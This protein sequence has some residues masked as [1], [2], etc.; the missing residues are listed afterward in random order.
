MRG[1]ISLSMKKT[2]DGHKRTLRIVKRILF[3]FLL[4]IAAG[5]A[6]MI[7]CLF[8]EHGLF[9]L[10]TRIV[11]S[12]SMEKNPQTDT[13]NYAIPDI[14]A[15]SLILIRLVPPGEPERGAFYSDL[16]PGDVL[17]FSYKIIGGSTVI[18]HRIQSIEKRDGGYLIVL[19]GDNGTHVGTQTIDTSDTQSS[20][21][22]IGKVIL[23]SHFLGVL[24]CILRQPQSFIVLCTVV[25]A[26]VLMETIGRKGSSAFRP[27]SL[28][29]GGTMKNKIL[30][31]VV[32]LL[33]LC[34]LALAI[35]ISYGLYDETVSIQTHL[36]A[37]SLK[38]TLERVKLTTYNIGS[39]GNFSNV[40]DDSVK[41]FSTETQDNIFGITEGT[42]IAPGSTFTAEMRIANGGNVA[43]YYYIET[44]YNTMVSD[45][46]FA[47]MLQ[48]TVSAENGVQ[49]EVRLSDG[50]TQGTEDEAIGTVN[51]GETKNFT[52]TL[53][54]LDD[55]NNNKVENKFV[56]FDICIHAVQKI[57]AA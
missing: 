33:V 9:G 56:L 26:A 35:G 53:K 14:P 7:A 29:A 19:C 45:N 6:V 51:V 15:G 28:R 20:N 36:V 54:F 52:V 12:S 10:Q 22:V 38:A 50:L 23:R 37:G 46:T 13:E 8:G 25:L 40:V 39:D 24:L 27:K 11:M 30:I 17:T 31:P 44:M 2:K 43:F 57:E 47:S 34:C 32:A 49:R 4:F 42:Q 48:L 18:T 1:R 41:D 16:I 55:E 5:S 3:F 21:R